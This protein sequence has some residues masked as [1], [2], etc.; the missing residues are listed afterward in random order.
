MRPGAAGVGAANGLWLK[1]D[2]AGASTRVP[3][4]RP[5]SIGRDHTCDIWLDE[6]TVSR[7]H[8]VVSIVNGRVHIDAGTSTNGIK[9]EE[10]N[11]SKATLDVGQSFDIGNT[12]FSVVERPVLAAAAPIPAP[13]PAPVAQPTFGGPQMPYPPYPQPDFGPAPR[14]ARRNSVPIIAVGAIAVVLVVIVVGAIIGMA[15]LNPGGGGSTTAG[16][17]TNPALAHAP[18]RMEA[19]APPW[20]QV[21]ADTAGTATWMTYSLDSEGFSIR[22]PSDWTRVDSTTSSTYRWVSFYPPGSSPSQPSSNISFLFRPDQL[23]VQD[24][25]NIRTLDR[26]GYQLERPDGTAGASALFEIDL[27]YAGNRG[28]LTITI[29]ADLSLKG[30][31]K[32]MLETGRWTK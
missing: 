19:V 6:P 15:V 28:T 13:E 31:L 14:T 23:Y 26:D 22:F 24:A 8:A 21:T 2:R 29:N 3:L 10:G 7:H 16:G 11:A 25:S 27:P 32:A 4:N 17:V 18:A 12:K 1:W 5:L 30:R 20:D 9:L